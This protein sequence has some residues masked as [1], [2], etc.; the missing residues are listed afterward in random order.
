MF[1]CAH[2]SVVKKKNNKLKMFEQHSP[3]ILNYINYFYKKTI[4]QNENF[5]SRQVIN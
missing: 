2:T 5:T 3:I 1:T 4:G